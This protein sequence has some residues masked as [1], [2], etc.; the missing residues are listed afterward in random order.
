M[1]PKEVHENGAGNGTVIVDVREQHEFEESHLP[2]AVHVPRGH[3]EQRIEGAAPDKSQHVV[4]YCASGNRSALAANTMQ[5]LLG[6][7]NVIIFAAASLAARPATRSTCPQPH[8]RTARALL[9]SSPDPRDRPRGADEAARRQGAAARRR[10]ARLTGRALPGRRGRGH[11]RD[12]GQ[13]RGGP[14]EPP[15]PR[16]ATMSLKARIALVLSSCRLLVDHR[17]APERVVDEDHAVRTQPSEDLLVVA[18]VARL[19]GVDEREIDGRLCGKRSQRLDR[20]RDL[21]LDAIVDAATLPAFA[22]DRR[23]LFA[24][25]AAQQ[26]PPARAASDGAR[27]SS[28]EAVPTSTACV[29]PTT[30]HEDRL[31]APCSG[32]ICIIEKSDACARVSLINHFWTSSIGAACAMR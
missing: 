6:Y 24:D 7:E 20:G 2:G 8:G 11:A 4:L 28:R 10:R 23:P 12:R 18:R 16:S 9:P 13:R 15:V 1:D 3:L 5:E 26:R 17:A 22:R 29:T 27:R 30:A 21:Q 14:L 32:E 31:N 25:V 19:V